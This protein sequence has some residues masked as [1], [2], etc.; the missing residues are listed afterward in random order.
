MNFL[1]RSVT[2]GKH[3]KDISGNGFFPTNYVVNPYDDTVSRID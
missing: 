2:G 3:L 1:Y